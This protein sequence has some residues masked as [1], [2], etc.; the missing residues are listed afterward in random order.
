MSIH[1]SHF[2]ITNFDNKLLDL[3]DYVLVTPVSYWEWDNACEA[4]SM[5]FPLFLLD[6]AK[7]NGFIKNRKEWLALAEDKKIKMRE[8]AEYQKYLKLKEKFE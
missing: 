1:E 7:L 5:K 4:E 3:Y 2:I 8:K 6:G